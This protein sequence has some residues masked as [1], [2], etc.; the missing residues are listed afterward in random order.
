MPVRVT[1]PDP[2]VDAVR[3]CVAVER[4]PL[5]YCVETAD[6]PPGVELEDL[7]WDGRRQPVEVARP[8]IADGVVGVA[9]PVVHVAQPDAELTA[10]AIPY[11]AWANR[12]P[13]GMR[14]WIPR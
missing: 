7:R 4:G 12:R 6:A 1:E 11:Y 10:G 5:V 14:V 8:D 3:G 2:R 9:V 13:E